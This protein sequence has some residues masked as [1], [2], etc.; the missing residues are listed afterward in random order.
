MSINILHEQARNGDKAAV[1]R[2]FEALT[3][4]FRLFARQRVY[5]RD[6]AEEIVQEAL[7]VVFEKYTEIEFQTSF[8]GWA[9]A[10]LTNKIL[11]AGRTRKRRQDKLELLTAEASTRM[12]G[13]GSLEARLLECFK[14][15]NRVNNRYARIL[16]LHHQGYSVPEICGRLE[17]TRSN[18]YTILCRARSLLERCL[19]EDE[20]T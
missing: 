10:V 14:K 15:L 1:E 2:L 7:K 5:D 20:T 12:A 9:Y 13:D 11:S 3:A 6:E 18:L 16:N 19:N 4:R 17:V 8:A